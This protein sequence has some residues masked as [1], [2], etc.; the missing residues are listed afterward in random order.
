MRLIPHI[1]ITKRVATIILATLGLWPSAMAFDSSTHA[2]TSLLAQGSWAKVAVVESGIHFL[3]NQALAQMGFADPARVNV[4]G[5][6]AM[7][8]PDALTADTYLDDLPPV[9][10]HRTAAGIYFYAVGTRTHTK[11]VWNNYILSSNPFTNEGYYFLSDSQPAHDGTMPSTGKAAN[12]QGVTTFTEVLQYELDNTSPGET[13]HYLVGE[14]LKYTPSRSVQFTLDG[15]S[16]QDVKLGAAVFHNL[17]AASTWTLSKQGGES[18]SVAAPASSAAN[19]LHG[20]ATNTWLDVKQTG[21]NTLVATVT[22]NGGSANTR[23]ANLDRITVNYSRLIALPAGGTLRFST[24]ATAVTVAGTNASTQIWDVTNPVNPLRVEHSTPDAAGLTHFTAT[25]SGMRDY[26]VFDAGGTQ[27]AQPAFAAGVPNQDLHAMSDIDMVIFTPSQWVQQAQQ[28]AQYRTQKNGLNV[29]VV[30]QSLAF[31]EYSS[32]VADPAAFRKFLKMLYD[33]AQA[34][35]STPPRYVLFFG[36]STFDNRRLTPATANL[37]FTPIPQWQTDEGFNDNTS[38]ATDDI[39]GFLADNSGAQMY[40]DTLSVAIGRLPVTTASQ[41]QLMV[42]KIKEYENSSP[43]GAWRSKVVVIADDEDNAVHLRQADL[44]V[45]ELQKHTRGTNLLV[46]KIYI[47]AYE[48]TNGVAVGAREEFYR[49]LDEGTMWVSYVGHAS[50]TALSGEGILNYSDLGSFYLRHLPFF[51]AATCDFLRWDGSETSGAERLALTKGGGIIGAIA[52]T[53]PVYITNNGNL[54]RAMGRHMADDDN[55]AQPIAVGE[56]LRRAKN[57]LKNDDNKLRYVLLGD[58]SMRTL[59]PQHQVVVETVDG[60]ELPFP[61]DDDPVLQARQDLRLTGSVRHAQTGELIE[62]FNGSLTS[63]LYDADESVTTIGHGDGTRVS[64]DRHGTRLFA[65]TAAVNNGRFTLDIAMPTEVADNYRP[66][67][68]NLVATASDGTTAGGRERRLYVYGT[69]ENAEPDTIPPLIETMYLNHPTFE[70]GATVNGSPTLIADL[71][72]NH[73]INMSLA[74]IGHW[75][76]LSLDYGAITYNDV[77]NYYQAVATD[78]GTLFYP[79]EGL[80]D[81][82]HTLT[83]RVWD[84]SGNSASRTIEFFVD[85]TTAPQVFDIYP[86]KNPVSETAN[87]YL[88]HDRP[89]AELKVELMVY[90]LMGRTV[91]T[92]SSTGRADKYTSFPVSWNLTDNAGRRVSRGIYIYRAIVTDLSSSGTDGARGATVTPAKKLAVTSR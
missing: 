35:L 49:Q 39:I 55:D 54:T 57:D 16:G 86:D 78:H 51:Y 52:A 46:E 15:L 50:T 90:D 1:N 63:T 62:D 77:S 66:A 65:G 28:L 88:V 64:F 58:P 84:A 68:L 12:A 2:S 76:S 73:A 10:V 81:G 14:D 56:I 24:E 30:E 29:A 18:K 21:G 71:S 17:N 6:G 89:D 48:Y 70:N 67:T 22:L 42:D 87:F 91:W 82:A 79:L 27:M 59:M 3:S 43:Q 34:G 75:M 60:R 32:G 85:Q 5:Y 38:Y 8:I 40:N 9:A 11:D 47:D 26:A 44:M 69:D 80:D 23:A 13:G 41:A 25:E 33:R 53:R 92:N 74:G 83:L 4:Y 31:N 7:R 20:T 72:D 61:D 36:R 37:T 45:D 19:N